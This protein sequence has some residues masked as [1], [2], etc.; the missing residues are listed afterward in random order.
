[1]ILLTGATGKTGGAAARALAGKGLRL[2][3][4]VRNAEKAKSLADAGIELVVGDM[5]DEAVLSRAMAGVSTVTLILP[6]SE[7]QLEMELRF[8]DHAKASGV[9]HIVKLSSIEAEPGV[10][11]EI[12]ANHVKIEAYIRASGLAWTMVRPNFFMQNLFGNARTIK[13]QSK[14]FLPCGDGKT[15]M[16]DARDVGLVIAAVLS[17]TGHENKSY[18]ITG[19]QALSFGQVAEIFSDVLGR[20]IEYVNLTPAS[21]R[22]GLGKFIT[23]PWHLNAVCEL[24]GGIAEGGLEATTDT[25]KALTGREPVPL[26]QFIRD[27]IAMYK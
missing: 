19:P 24:I 6:N 11:Q 8:V 14:F 21:Y 13:E 5:A 10:K 16:S 4:I 23:N 26:A 2:R 12:P 25:F 3:A 18:A 22:E 17:G 9:K 15:G 7:K 27:H 20:K 1:M